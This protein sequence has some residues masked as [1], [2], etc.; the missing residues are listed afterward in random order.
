VPGHKKLTFFLFPVTFYYPPSYYT[1]NSQLKLTLT[2]E[3]LYDGK[4]I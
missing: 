3:H 1:Q 4:G 2:T